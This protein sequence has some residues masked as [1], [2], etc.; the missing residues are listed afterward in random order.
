MKALTIIM[1]VGLCFYANA[2]S[3]VGIGTP[4]PQQAVHVASATGTVR[5]D[6]MN[7]TNNSYNGG[8]VNG[9]M[10][11]DEFYPLYVDENGDLTLELKIEDSTTGVDELDDAALPNSSVTMTDADADGVATT[12]ITT[13]TVT[14]TRSAI[15]EVKYNLSFDVY[16]DNAGTLITDDLARRIFTYLTI[17][18]QTREY[19]PATKCYSSGAASSVSDRMYN[20]CSAYIT[21][22]SA[23]AWTISL[24][25]GVSSD[26]RSGGGPGG[27]ALDTHVEFATGTDSILMRLH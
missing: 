22:P 25:G 12:T 26:I 24:I 27:P 17:N 9:N 19:G 23:G 1:C 4:N 10:I 18:G 5:I 11:K 3:G 6:G 14:T 16:E 21:I 2:Q 15:L 20:N 13:F 7:A 8:D